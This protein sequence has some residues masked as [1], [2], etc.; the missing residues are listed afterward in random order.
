MTE[1]AHHF[2]PVPSRARPAR[3]PRVPAE[4]YYG[5]HTARALR[6]LRHHRHPVARLPRAGHR[7]GRGQAGRRARPT[8]SWA[9][10]PDALADAD[11]RG[12]PGD[13]RGRAARPVRRRRDPGRRRHV[14]QHERQRGDRQPR[15]GARSGHR[16]GDYA[17]LHPL[18][19]VNLAEHQRRLPDG[20]QAR[21]A[22]GLPS[23]CSR[24]WT[25]C[26]APSRPRPTSSPTSSRS[27]A[28]SCRTPCR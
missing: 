11:R 12:L 25:S 8:G 5:V 19:H 22:P 15:P 3:R 14:D 17:A 18:D 21:P 20:R 6:E 28:P 9:C 16:A 24:R 26:G 7:A 1:E 27:A 13:P 10:S 23:G 4:A 2:R